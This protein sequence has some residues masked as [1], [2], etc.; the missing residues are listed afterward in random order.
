[1]LIQRLVIDQQDHYDNFH[2]HP[3]TIKVSHK[4]LPFELLGN[5]KLNPA[6]ESLAAPPNSDGAVVVAGLPNRPPDGADVVVA[7]AAPGVVD[8]TA[9]SVGLVTVL[10]VC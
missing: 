7:G 9:S 2:F 6:P 3:S 4:F 8:V 5:V 10:P 1:M